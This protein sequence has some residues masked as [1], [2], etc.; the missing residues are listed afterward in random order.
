MQ[1]FVYFSASDSI[2]AGITVRTIVTYGANLI[3]SIFVGKDKDYDRMRLT[4]W[5]WGKCLW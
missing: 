2:E 1:K 4:E 5:E 3:S